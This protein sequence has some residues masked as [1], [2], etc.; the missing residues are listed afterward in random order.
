MTVSG[1]TGYLLFCLPVCSLFSLSLSVCVCLSNSRPTSFMQRQH[2]SDAV[3]TPSSTR[4]SSVAAAGGNSGGGASAATDGTT[5]LVG[6]G[7]S[8]STT[9]AL[10]HAPSTAVGSH[11]VAGT[12]VTSPPPPPSHGLGRGVS[13]VAGAGAGAGVAGSRAGAGAGARFHSTRNQPSTSAA[14]GVRTPHSVSANRGRQA[15]PLTQ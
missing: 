10:P 7:G 5:R 3:A 12:A 11:A 15:V 14:P 9:P 1:V 8:G 4:S 6:T 2:P 13:V